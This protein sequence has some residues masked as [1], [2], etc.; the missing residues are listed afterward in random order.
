VLP[1][2]NAMPRDVDFEQALCADIAG[3]SLHAAA[4]CGAEDRQALEQLCR[5]ITRP[6]LANERVQYNAAGQVVLKLKA[7]WRDGATCLELS[8]LQ[9]MRRL[10]KGRFAAARFTGSVSAPGRLPAQSNGR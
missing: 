6:A 2:Q 1:V 3:F 8:P 10:S 9:L 4:R 7:P 5:N